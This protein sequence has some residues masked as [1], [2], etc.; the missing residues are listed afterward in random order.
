MSVD[1]AN[2]LTHFILINLFIKSGLNNSLLSPLPSIVLVQGFFDEG[3]GLDEWELHL[4]E[5]LRR[6]CRTL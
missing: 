2:S 5:S 4:I 3:A 6:V 1:G